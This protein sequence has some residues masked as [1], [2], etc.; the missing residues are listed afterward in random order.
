M[1]RNTPER[2]QTRIEELYLT[3][4]KTG[5]RIRI[6]ETKIISKTIQIPPRCYSGEETGPHKEDVLGAKQRREPR[7]LYFS[8]SSPHHAFGSNCSPFYTT[9]PVT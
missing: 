8:P 1:I 5:P 4:D 6:L 3:N 7:A 9:P 2:Q